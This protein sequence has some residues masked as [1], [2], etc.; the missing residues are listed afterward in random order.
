MPAGARRSPH[1]PRGYRYPVGTSTASTCARPVQRARV[2]SLTG[3]GAESYPR[4]ALQGRL[5]LWPAGLRNWGRWRPLGCAG[6][7]GACLVWLAVAVVV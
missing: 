3:L 2:P 6:S 1:A 4:M 7:S 5:F